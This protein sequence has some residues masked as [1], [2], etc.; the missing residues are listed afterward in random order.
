MNRSEY[1]IEC[2]SE[3]L[4]TAGVVATQDQIK[5]IARDMEGGHECIGM[6]F[7]DDVASANLSAHRE[8]EDSALKA[9]LRREK[10][11]RGCPTCGGRGRLQ[12]S[13]GPWAVDTQCSK[14]HGDG[15]IHPS[16]A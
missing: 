7:G 9:E 4:E 12:Y 15:K 2:V 3:A 14:C 13:A 11:K 1:W 5:S 10:E 8:R 6:A 16:Q